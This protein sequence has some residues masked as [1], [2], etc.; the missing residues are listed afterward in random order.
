MQDMTRIAK[1]CFILH[2]M[3]VESRR[4]NYAGSRAIQI[5]DDGVLPDD[6]EF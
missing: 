3:C 5:L 1:A 6:L 2:N 4:D